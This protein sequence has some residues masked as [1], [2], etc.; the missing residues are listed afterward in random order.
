MGKNVYIF[1]ADIN[2]SL[3]I[4][5]RN[6]YILILS[7]GQTQG[8]DDTTLTAEVKYYITLTQS[9]KRFVLSLHSNENNSFLFVN[10]TK[11][12]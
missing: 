3:H 9:R 5:K 6:K 12:N 4:D 7:E 11:I 8:L 2:S 1:G 10:A